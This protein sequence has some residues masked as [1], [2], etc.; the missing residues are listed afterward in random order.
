[1][2]LG[3]AKMARK[4][5]GQETLNRKTWKKTRNK[6]LQR[7]R[8]HGVKINKNCLLCIYAIPPT[9]EGATIKCSH[10][11]PDVTFDT[12]KGYWMCHSYVQDKRLS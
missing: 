4:K 2:Y 8:H 11:K 6:K 7:E 9:I 3:P 12:T 1:M 10:K 5:E